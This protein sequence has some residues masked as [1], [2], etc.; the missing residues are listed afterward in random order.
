MKSV[1][2][3][4]GSARLASHRERIQHATDDTICF[5]LHVYHDETPETGEFEVFVGLEIERLEGVPMDLTVRVLPEG[6]YAK[7]TLEGEEIVS[8]WHMKV[9]SEWLPAAGREGLH[10]HSYQRY[11]S[12]FKGLEHLSESVLDV[13]IPVRR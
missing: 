5:E 6:R 10:T 1:G 2:P 13:F 7:F 12:R 11:D 8:D 9:Y 3:G 4:N